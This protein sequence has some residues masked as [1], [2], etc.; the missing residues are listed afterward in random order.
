MG[1]DLEYIYTGFHSLKHRVSNLKLLHNNI[2]KRAYVCQVLRLC[3]WVSNALLLSYVL[4]M[5]ISNTERGCV[6]ILG[7]IEPLN[8][9]TRSIYS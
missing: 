1:L 6:S 4:L 5:I 2:Y 8:M 9:G 7:Y 3:C